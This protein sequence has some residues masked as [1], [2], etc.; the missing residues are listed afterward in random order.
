MGHLNVYAE[1]FN[2]VNDVNMEKPQR[3][4]NIYGEREDDWNYMQ[5]QVSLFH[6][7]VCR[8]ALF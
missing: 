2:F 4:K 3:V 8:M 6:E 5:V 1:P 7:A